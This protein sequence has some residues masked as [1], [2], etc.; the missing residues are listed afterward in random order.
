M[1]GWTKTSPSKFAVKLGQESKEVVAKV[2]LELHSRLVMKTPVDTGRARSNW[3]VRLDAP[4]DGFKPSTGGKGT[5]GAMT[6]ILEAQ[7]RLE[8]QK[9]RGLPT[10]YIT[11]NLPYI[12]YLNDGS[13]EQAPKHFIETTLAEV[14]DAL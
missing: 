2:A 13:S 7:R 10:V 14:S 6:T 5:Q 11:N 9:M 4:F 12:K 1:A 3:Q 8:P